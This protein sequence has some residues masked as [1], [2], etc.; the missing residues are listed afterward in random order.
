[1]SRPNLVS[2]CVSTNYFPPCILLLLLP[3][4]TTCAQVNA[5]A[6]NNLNQLKFGVQDAMHQPQRGAIYKHLDPMIAAATAAGAACCYLSGAGPSVLA[7]TTGA[8]GD[9]FAQRE[10]ERV[11]RKVADAMI[12]AAEL[13]GVQGQVFI[14]EPSLT[15]AYVASVEPPFSGGLVSYRGDV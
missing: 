1:M 10:K 14:T 9:I 6:T 13:V 4:S 7:I 5:L 3:H 2:L 12:A 11:D 8:A 15:G